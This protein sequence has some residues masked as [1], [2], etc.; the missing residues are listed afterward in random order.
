MAEQVPALHVNPMAPGSS[1][2]CLES[3]LYAVVSPVYP[4]ALR[5]RFGVKPEDVQNWV[6]WLFGIEA[7]GLMV[8]SP[9]FG[10]ISDRIAKRKRLLVW[11]TVVLL[12]AHAMQCFARHMALLVLGRFLQGGCAGVVWCIGLA[13]VADTAESNRVGQMLGYA[14]APYSAAVAL[15]PVLG[16]II[17]EKAGYYAVFGLGFGLIGL[18]LVLLPLLIEEKDVKQ[19]GQRNGSSDSEL[20]SQVQVVEKPE[21]KKV[22]TTRSRKIETGVFSIP[23]GDDLHPTTSKES[24][25]SASQPSGDRWSTSSLLSSGRSIKRRISKSPLWILIKSRRL[26][27][28]CLANIV[29]AMI[30][31]S[32]DVTLPLFAEE[33]FAWTP[34]GS[35]LLFL[36][37]AVPTVLQP[38]WGRLADKYGTRFPVFTGLLL[39]VAPYACLRLVNH[40]S[41]AQVVALCSLLFFIG[42]GASLSLAATMADFSCVANEKERKS[43]GSMGKT[44]ALA[45]SYVLFNTSW[46]IGELVGSNIAGIMR[47]GNGW[48]IMGWCFA[49]ICGAGAI[50][51][52]LWCEGWIVDNASRRQRER[53]EAYSSA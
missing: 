3:W 10:Y 26:Q 23:L 39:C 42:L 28:T 21:V 34:L 18:Q 14:S 22:P 51:A 31:A 11:S 29:T 32:F 52:L 37:L 9:I 16:G 47:Q 45:Q 50:I 27:A 53:K 4:T 49:A 8:S 43:P 44:G 25:L 2:F 24:T 38:L 20:V 5:D 17:Y 36:A 12:G 19:R 41:V 30:L 7:A 46:G 15:G 33:I 35:G 48:G 1:F 13:L 40:K 6:D